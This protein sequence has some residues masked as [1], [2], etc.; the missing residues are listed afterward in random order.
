MQASSAHLRPLGNPLPLALF[1][2]AAGTLTLSGLQLGWIPVSESGDVAIALI[3]FSFPLQLIAALLAYP[4]RDAAVAEGQAMSA[5]GWLVIGLVTLTSTPG[6]TSSALGVFLLAVALLLLAPA[7][8]SLSTKAVVAAVVVGG[9]A[10]SGGSGTVVGAAIGAFF[11]GLINNALLL[12]LLPQ[13]LL[14]VV[15]G[16]VILVAVATDAFIRQRARRPTVGAAE[17]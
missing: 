6:S 5:G 1:A 11:L 2:L 9:V 16:A 15:Y 10:I 12:L 3:G 4:A 8:A 13:E 7:A 14:Q 17:R